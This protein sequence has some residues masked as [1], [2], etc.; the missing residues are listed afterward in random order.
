[1]ATDNPVLGNEFSVKCTVAGTPLPAIRWQFN[2]RALEGGDNF[3][4]VE[5]SN[6]Q[7]SIVEV[8]DATA[9]FSGEYTCTAFNAA[10]SMN[11]SIHIEL[12]CKSR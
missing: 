8:S 7:T 6:G 3:R 10:G 4:I 12:Q 9:E 1:M 11:Q 5:T 2:D